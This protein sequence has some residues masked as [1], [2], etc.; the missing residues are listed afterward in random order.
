LLASA[1]CLGPLVLVL[2][3]ISGAWIS[4]LAALQPYQPLFIALSALELL[5][6]WR[7]IWRPVACA[8]GQVCALP[9][10]KFGYKL[11]FGLVVIL[12]IVALGSPFIASWFY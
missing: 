2:V 5:F 11:L 8:P 4:N 1:C 10:I 9:R 7:Q 12:S 6:A 3:G